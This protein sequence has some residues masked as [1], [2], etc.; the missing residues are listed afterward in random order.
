VW[1]VRGC[2][3]ISVGCDGMG[4]LWGMVELRVMGFGSTNTTCRSAQLHC[5]H[6]LELPMTL[7]TTG[8]RKSSAVAMAST[9]YWSGDSGQEHR[10]SDGCD[11]EQ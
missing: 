5:R 10:R 7:M 9:N 8:I 3:G 6:V 11:R 1:N 2:D 4:G